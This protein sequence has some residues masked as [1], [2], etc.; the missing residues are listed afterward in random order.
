MSA[1]AG[2]PAAIAIVRLCAA[3]TQKRVILT[4]DHYADTEYAVFHNDIRSYSK[5]FERFLNEPRR[6]GVRFIRSYVSIGKDP[7]TKM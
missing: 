6:F 2:L 5:D 4:K 1:Q 7:E 3:Y